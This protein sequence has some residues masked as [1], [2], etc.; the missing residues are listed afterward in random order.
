MGDVTGELSM[1]IHKS[2]FCGG[3]TLAALLACANAPAAST[4]NL[5]FVGNLVAAACTITT[6]GSNLAEVVF[7]SLSAGDL[8]L[9]GQSARQP[10]IF[11]LEA[12]DTSLSNGIRVTFTGNA[13]SGM[14]D[15]LA[16][17]GRSTAS[18]VGIGL[19]TL[20]G[21]AVAVNGST[22][23]TFVLTTGNNILQLNAWV[24]VISGQTIM[25]GSFTAT[26]TAK[27]EYL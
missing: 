14:S 16:L 6:S 8:L 15:I 1:S 10:V 12:C 21:E 27:F 13:V 23:A 20:K 3:L 7:P 9:A 11:T 24:Q 26:A 17:D 18:G 25:P 22:G 5:H 2:L 19:E 4:N